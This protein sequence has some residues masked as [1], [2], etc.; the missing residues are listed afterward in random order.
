MINQIEAE[1]RLLGA[2]I[3][4]Y[5]TTIASAL[6]KL[7]AEHFSTTST[8]F[9]FGAIGRIA[10]AGR[11]V[12][13]VT[14]DTEVRLAVERM[15]LPIECNMGW[16]VEISVNAVSSANAEYYAKLIR[17]NY[18]MRSAVARLDEIKQSIIETQDPVSAM[19]SA[20]DALISM[21]FGVERSKPRRADELIDEYLAHR[22]AIFEG[23]VSDGMRLKTDGLS[24]AFGPIGH[25][26]FIVIAGRPGSGKSECAVA[27]A[28]DFAI[29]QGKA[30]L[31]KSLE[32]EG[33]EVAERAL[34]ATAGISVDQIS[35]G[36][37]FTTDAGCGAMGEAVERIMG[38]PFYIDDASGC[39]IDDVASDVREF[40]AEHAN[41]GAVI[42]DYVGLLDIAGKFSRHDLAIGDITRK[43]KLLAKQ[44]KIPVIGLFQLSRDV[45]KRTGSKKPLASDL[46]DSGSIEQDADKIVM[47][48]RECIYDPNTPMQN[49]AEL[50]N[51]KRRRGQPTN[52]YMRFV[53]GHFVAIPDDEQ[54][55]WRN[56]A[57][58]KPEP[59]QK[60]KSGFRY[61]DD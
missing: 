50:L 54:G 12:D 27:L 4:S 47:V 7:K 15:E 60:K 17:T 28:C 9:V 38:K 46:R 2:A 48:H 55:K 26:D 3:A 33:V 42:I 35:D 61:G 37:A 1:E 11:P 51:V 18:A 57:E 19:Q 21:D 8:R 53:N 29:D 23:A 24:H 30:V 34:L 32:M 25:T 45:E 6:S 13:L 41:V 22:M 40:C 58:S 52:G 36:T 39:T 10:S 56:I 59:E 16:L 5:T 44:M 31:Y 14:V 49:V 20:K 43:M